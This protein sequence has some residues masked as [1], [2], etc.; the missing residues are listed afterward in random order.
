MTELFCTA[1]ASAVTAGLSVVSLPL[2]AMHKQM[3][4]KE[5]AMSKEDVSKAEA[6]TREEA[7]PEKEVAKHICRHVYSLVAHAIRDD[8][9][10]TYHNLVHFPLGHGFRGFLRDRFSQQ[11]LS[12]V[13]TSKVI[14]CV[15]TEKE[16][17]MFVC[18]CTNG[19]QVAFQHEGVPALGRFLSVPRQPWLPE[20]VE[21]KCAGKGASGREAFIFHSDYTIQSKSCG[22]WLWIDPERNL[23]LLHTKEKSK[24]DIVAAA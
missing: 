15:P 8:M 10:N 4:S 18:H 1:A 6:T 3:P 19:R 7:I 22:H 24:W 2:S 14:S 11:Y 20:C 13:E 5:K 9:L 21:L 16:V 23:L 17:S 12:V